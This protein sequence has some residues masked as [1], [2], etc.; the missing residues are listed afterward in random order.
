MLTR[1]R[2][3]KVEKQGT[4]K[5]GEGKEGKE[6]IVERAGG[7]VG[8][9]GGGHALGGGEREGGLVGEMMLL[10]LKLDIDSS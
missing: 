8:G 6:V 5:A 7:Q 4:R 2:G 3:F 1:R 9:R 10:C